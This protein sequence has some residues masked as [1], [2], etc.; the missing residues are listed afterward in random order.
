MRK[1]EDLEIGESRL[2]GPLTVD[3]DDMMDFARKYDPQWFHADADAASG[4]QFGEVIASGVYTAAL[5]RKLDHSINSDIDFICGV[6][7]ED[8]HWPAAVKAGDALRA[9]STVLEKRASQGDPN[10]GVAVFLYRL[11]NQHDEEVFSCRSINLVR[12]REPP[13]QP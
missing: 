4:S 12:R 6:A 13:D 8:V 5:W 9:A 3:R 11:I 7:W 10:R 2:S 1:F